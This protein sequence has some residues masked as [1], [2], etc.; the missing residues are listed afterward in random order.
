MSKINIVIHTSSDQIKYILQCIKQ[1]SKCEGLE[2]YWG[3]K[4]GS[5]VGDY[6]MGAL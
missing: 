5:L 4:T 2:Q 6:L 1:K 3:T